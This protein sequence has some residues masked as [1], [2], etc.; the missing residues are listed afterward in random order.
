MRAVVSLVVVMPAK[1]KTLNLIVPLEKV[2][3]VKKNRV[4]IKSLKRKLRRTRRVLNAKKPLHKPKDRGEIKSQ[5]C[6]ETH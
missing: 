1:T 5:T 2:N 4:K 3:Q 6:G